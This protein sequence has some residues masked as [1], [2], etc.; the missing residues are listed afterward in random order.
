MVK[1]ERELGRWMFVKS[2]EQTG[3]YEDLKGQE[4]HRLEELELWRY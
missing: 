4:D 1:I 2:T 3:R